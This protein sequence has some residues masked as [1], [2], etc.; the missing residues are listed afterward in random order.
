VAKTLISMGWRLPIIQV[1][2]FFNEI[3]F[4]IFAFLMAFH[5][6]KPS[7]QFGAIRMWIIF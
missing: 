1:C 5:G 3:T 6:N 7:I 4:I 2:L